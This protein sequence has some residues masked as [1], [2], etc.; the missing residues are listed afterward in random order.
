MTRRAST[1]TYVNRK[2]VESAVLLNGRHGGLGWGTAPLPLFAAMLAKAEA[3][4]LAVW[5][6]IDA[7]RRAIEGGEFG[8][9]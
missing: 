3:A 2:A 8:R 1:S 5:E 7:M 4:E 9:R 6:N